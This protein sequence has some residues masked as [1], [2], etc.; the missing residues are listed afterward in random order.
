MQASR[1]V[2]WARL[3]AGLSQQELATR[4]G[5]A[6]STI[7]RIE[8]GKLDPRYGTVRTLLRACGSDLEVWPRIGSDYD[9]T[10][11]RAQLRREPT[12]RLRYAVAGA[13]NL[14]PLFG[15]ARRQLVRRRGA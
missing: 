13:N 6:Q 8:S 2:R 1:Y 4:T 5:I 9:R 15:L 12:D 11:I 14:R 10:E 3:H 7:S